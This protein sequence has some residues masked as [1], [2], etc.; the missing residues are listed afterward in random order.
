[1]IPKFNEVMLP[2]LKLCAD[3]E[4]HSNSEVLERMYVHFK[5]TPPEIEERLPSGTQTVIYNRTQW[6]ITYL[7]KA[8]L[9]ENVKRSEFKITSR[10]QDV[11]KENPSEI[12]V[13]YLKRFDEFKT[14]QEVDKSSEDS[15][16]TFTEQTP[17]DVLT[18][19]YKQINSSLKTEIIERLLKVS[20]F[21]FEEIVVKV[22][23]NLGYGGTFEEAGKAFKKSGDEGID[24]VIS[25]DR[26]GLDMIYV[27]AKRYALDNKVGRPLVQEFCGALMGKKAKKGIFIT[28]SSYTREAEEY[29]K[30]I[31]SKII[32]I[33][34]DQ[35][36]QYMI[37]TNSGV[38]TEFTYFIKRINM[39]FFE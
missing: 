24:G 20:P 30:N 16:S 28:T 12:N 36:A 31:D 18:N 17:T 23:I 4:I 39:D 22:L 29:V 15:E 1:M 8:K 34:G 33:N 14:F 32:L 5:L 10:G 25:E 26:L 37:E 9:I 3:G 27:Q 2:T 7:R 21:K 38:E 35:L 11:L 19:A 13:K 6:A